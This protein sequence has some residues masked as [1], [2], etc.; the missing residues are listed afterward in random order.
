MGHFS[1]PEFVTFVSN[2]DPNSLREP[3]K[4]QYRTKGMVIKMT[5]F[6]IQMYSLRDI[7]KSDM[8]RALSE[9][10]RMGYKTAEF[11]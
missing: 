5:E 2:D 3:H 7:T 10:A 1:D 6:G 4:L 8:N 11:A 9:I